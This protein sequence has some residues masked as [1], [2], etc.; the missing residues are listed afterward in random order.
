MECFHPKLYGSIFQAQNLTQRVLDQAS[1]MTWCQ[2]VPDVLIQ[3]NSII[4]TEKGFTV[5]LLKMTNSKLGKT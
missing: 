5:G 3:D 1:K 2:S 4:A